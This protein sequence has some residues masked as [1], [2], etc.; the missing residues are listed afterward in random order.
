M[1]LEAWTEFEVN[2][3]E[4]I[5]RNDPKPQLFTKCENSRESSDYSYVGRQTR[6]TREKHFGEFR[7]C[8]SRF[9]WLL[10]GNHVLFLVSNQVI[11]DYYFSY[12][13]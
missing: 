6:G 2:N 12:L 1:L 3:D 10:P 8:F 11:N 4:F 5:V 13:G 7:A 9:Q